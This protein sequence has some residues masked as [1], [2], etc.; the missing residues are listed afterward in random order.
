M[1]G[2]PQTLSRP[3]HRTTTATASWNASVAGKPLSI[4]ENRRPA[5]DSDHL[6]LRQGQATWARW[7]GSHTSANVTTQVAGECT[8]V[9]LAQVLDSGPSTDRGRSAAARSALSGWSTGRLLAGSA[10]GVSSSIAGLALLHTGAAARPGTGRA[11]DGRKAKRR[12]GRLVA[13]VSYP[14]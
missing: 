4:D 12:P 11:R 13:F 6:V 10:A 9:Q 14:R 2:Q 5:R 3:P 7:P 1:A 8:V